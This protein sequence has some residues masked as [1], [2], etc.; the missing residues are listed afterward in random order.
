LADFCVKKMPKTRIN[1]G[2]GLQRSLLYAWTC[3][4]ICDESRGGGWPT[5]RNRLEKLIAE[6][7]GLAKDKCSEAIITVSTNS[8]EGEDASIEI[9]VPSYDF[10]SVDETVTKR[11]DEI[12]DDEGYHIVVMVFEKEQVVALQMD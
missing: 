12:F 4:N 3:Q 6:L 9:I 8:L 1:T 11:S 5:S 2:F 10:D 7:S